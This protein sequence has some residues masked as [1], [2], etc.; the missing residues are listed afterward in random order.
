MRTT[1]SPDQIRSFAKDGYLLVPDLVDQVT[2]KR[3]QKAVDALAE[4]RQA[5]P[6]RHSYLRQHPGDVGPVFTRPVRAASDQLAG[7]LEQQGAIQVTLTVPPFAVEPDGGH[8]DGFDA[9]DQHGRPLSFTL[10][11]GVLLSDQSREGMGNLHVW[12]GTH[13]SAAEQVRAHGLDAFLAGFADSRPPVP[14]G[15]PV[16]VL[17]GAGDVVLVH[18]LLSHSIGGNTSGVVRRT[19]Y[20]RLRRRGHDRVSFWTDPWHEYDGVRAVLDD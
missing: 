10:L 6:G 12:P 19:V 1:L 17:G 2:V 7:P 13:L 3:A 18:Y 11:V 14:H 15:S 9:P 20:S 4:R 8:L 5:G 16:Q